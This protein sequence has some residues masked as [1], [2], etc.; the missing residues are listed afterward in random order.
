MP[1]PHSPSRPHDPPGGVS[2][3]HTAPAQCASSTH[4][5]S[6]AHAVA[7]L[8]GGWST[9]PVQNTGSKRPHSSASVVASHP[10][11]SGTP[12]SV[13]HRNVS[14]MTSPR[15]PWHVAASSQM[16]VSVPPP[17]QSVVTRQHDPPLQQTPASQWPELQSPSSS[18]PRPSGTSATQSAAS[19]CAGA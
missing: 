7:Q 14:Q 6:S 12:P 4:S 18:Q 9:S 1:V 10:L 13:V 15:V 17:G 2:A 16:A 5:A 3:T 11:S 8:G 19:Q